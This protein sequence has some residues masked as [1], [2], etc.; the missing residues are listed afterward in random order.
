LPRA[1]GRLRGAATVQVNSEHHVALGGQAVGHGPDVV[2]EPPPLVNQDHRGQRLEHVGRRSK[3][4]VNE[5]IAGLGVRHARIRGNGAR[6]RDLCRRARFGGV[7]RVFA[8]HARDSVTPCRDLRLVGRRFLTTA[9]GQ[10]Q[11][12]G[13][14][15]GDCLWSSGAGFGHSGTLSELEVG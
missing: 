15:Q 9:A 12:R 7:L 5:F 2:V 1:L 6:R 4:A 13:Q 3:V 8:R 10:Q 14:Q 11:D